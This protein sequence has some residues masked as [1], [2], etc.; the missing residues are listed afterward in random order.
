M[1]DRLRITDE[2]SMLPLT[3][4]LEGEKQRTLNKSWSG[5]GVS[6]QQRLYSP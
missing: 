4:S 2:P 1:G 3:L 5:I 6:S